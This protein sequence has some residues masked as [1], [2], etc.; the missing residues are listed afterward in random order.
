[1]KYD[2]EAL[3]CPNCGAPLDLKP[4][5]E[6]T[7]CLYCNST[8]RISKHGETGEQVATHTEMSHDKFNEIK[9]LILAGKKDEAI[10]MYQKVAN[11]TKPEAEKFV[12]TI[13]DKLTYI[14]IINRPLSIKGFLFCLLLMLLIVASL[15]SL[16][17][18]AAK[19]TLF[20]TIC[21]VLLLVSAFNLLTLTREIITTIKF[22]PVKWTK[23]TILKFK[24]MNQKKKFS[25]F[26]V[27]LD[28]KTPDGQSFQ[29]ETN[30]MIKTENAAKLQEGKLI[31]VKYRGKE[32]ND[33]IAS[34]SNL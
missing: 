18:G 22:F 21:W 10:E 15:Y 32:K 33:I 6:I 11:V 23:A 27:L 2:I 25:F 14:I 17:S 4:G 24:F 3:T 19:E 30:I 12:G 26:K 13:L 7:F 5:E 20:N 8:V 29:S 16:I 9:Q 34:V 31:D 28:V 1:M